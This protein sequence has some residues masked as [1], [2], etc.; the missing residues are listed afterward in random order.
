MCEKPYDR[1]G[2]HKEHVVKHS[3]APRYFTHTEF[4]CNSNAVRNEIIHERH[5]AKSKLG[6]I[7][8]SHQ[9]SNR[10]WFSNYIGDMKTLRELLS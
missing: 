7:D 5:L 6:L 2:F 4:Q 8:F 3:E 9:V 1:R 10:G